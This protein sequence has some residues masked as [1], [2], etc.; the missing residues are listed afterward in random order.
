MYNKRLVHLFISAKIGFIAVVL[1]AI[2]D[3]I[4]TN[5]GGWGALSIW[6]FVSLVIYLLLQHV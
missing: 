2:T 4:L 5:Y 3:V 1:A 6:A